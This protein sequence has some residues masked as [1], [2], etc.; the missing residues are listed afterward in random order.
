MYASIQL[1]AISQ[2]SSI[3]KLMMTGCAHLKKNIEIS[4]AYS[5]MKAIKNDKL[6][7]DVDPNY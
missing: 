6:H 1:A 3:L 4:R 5:P 2:E 7:R